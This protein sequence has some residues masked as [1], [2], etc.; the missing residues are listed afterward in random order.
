METTALSVGKSVLNGA[1]DYAKSA[2]AEEVALQFGVQRDRAFVADELEMMQSFMMEAHEERDNNKVVK[3]WVKQV[4]DT[5]YDV[6]DS[7][8]DFA[9]RLERPSWWRFPRTLLER[10]HVAKQMKELRAKVEDVSQRNVRYRLIKD[11]GSKA[12]AATEQSSIIAAS[13]FGVGDARH[14]AKEE[15]HQSVDLVQLINKEADDLKVIAVWGTSGDIGQTTIIREA[16]ENTDVQIKFPC[17]AW[18][19]VMHPFCPKGFVQSL[20]NQFHATEGVEVL[21]KREQTEQDLAQ[22]FNSYVNEKRCLIVL[23]DLSTIEEW[24]QIKKCFQNNKKGSRIV[25]STSQVEVA[26]LC[27]AQESQPSELKQLSPDQTLYAF[28][29]KGSQNGK[30]SGKPA[31]RS[32]MATSSTKNYAVSLCKI[33]ED[34]FKDADGKKVV[35]KSKDSVKPVSSSDTATTNTN[36]QAVALGEITEVE[37][38]DADKKKVVTKSLTRIRTGV[39]AS[40]ESQLI[41][42]EREILEVIDLILNKGNEKGQVISVWGMGGLG[43]TT[44]VNGVYYSPKLSDKFEK[45]VF[46]PIMRPFNPA[47]HLRRLIGG[48]HEGSATKEDLLGNSISNKRKS[49]ASMGVEDLTKEVAKLLETK[50]CLI[51]LDDLSS[52]TEW[53]LRIPKFPQMKT[54]RIIVTTRYE[55]IA[56]HCIGSGKH[57]T[58]H[59]LKVLEPEDA[60]HLFNKKVFGEAKDLVDH[61]N[62][63]LIKEGKQILKKCGGLPLAIVAIGGYLASRPKTGIEWRKLN[64]NIS[65]ELEMNPELG[66]IRTVLAKSYDGLPYELKSCFLYLS[67]FPE[68]HVISRRRLVRRWT[69]E[70]YS[71]ERCGKSAN[72]I[73]ENYF[74]ELKNRSMTLPS[75]RSVRSRKS[76]DSCKVHDLIRDI[77][78]SKS[79][80]ENLVFSLEEGCGS[81][82]HGA[83]RHLAI[84]SNWKGDQSEFESIV[85]LSR[86]RSLTVFGNFR[87]FYISNKMRLLRVLDLEGIDR[88]QYHQL[89]HIWKLLHLKYLSLRGCNGI[90]LLSDSLGNLRQLQL[91]DVRNTCVKALPKAIIKL[92]KLQYIHAGYKSDF[93]QEEKDS[94]MWRCLQ[95]ACL[96]ATCCIPI[97]CDIDG[98]SHKALTRRDACT[99]A[100]CVKFP[101]LMMG[102]GVDEDEGTMV[103][104]GSR[105]LKDLHT[106]REVKV[107]RGIAVLQDI[108]LLTGLRKL[109]VSGI[110]K[111]NGP[112]FRSA[113]SNLNRLES[114]AV[115]SEAGKRGLRGCLDDIS[116]PPEN[117]QSLKL[118]GNLEKLPEWIK[119]LPH[120]VK[121]KLAYTRLSEHDAAMEFLGKLLKLEIL[122]LSGLWS[123]FEGEELY[124]KS[125][126]AGIAFGRL[127]VLS[128]GVRNVKLVKFEEGTMPKVE[129]LL[130]TGRVNNEPVSFS[131]LESLPSI[132]E[133]QL[134]VTFPWDE[135]K[136]TAAR[137]SKTWGRIWEEEEQEQRRKNGELKKKIQEQLAGNTNEPIVTV[138]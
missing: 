17:R 56:K 138:A 110:N 129:R 85:D 134:R 71:S 45:R 66:M 104:R 35:K 30:D 5:A 6:E 86:I 84:S 98:P 116:T 81:S 131:G 59:N 46:V 96:C 18:V 79:I 114:L 68:D 80:E 26:S 34:D 108:K 133:I 33:M 100:C 39:G 67:I 37:S 125:P 106:L 117:L 31:S 128:L 115:R 75:Q 101:A 15:N 126:Q 124:F 14:A 92:R 55:N 132:N 64:E 24:D 111:K 112:A 12:I 27:A 42:R 72:E 1:L 88:L 113:I 107:G 57:G 136:I 22:E 137:D 62:L 119:E 103:P 53:D 78:I 123:L 76:T 50:S 11:S 70:G 13:I 47:E 99:F 8:Q 51:V 25:V 109:G 29:D 38:K 89:D 20:V 94:L 58:I 118:Y 3:T 9:V 90:D 4:R 2:L 41:G 65:A 121:L 48:L 21:L 28:Y 36:N 52:T 61:K 82:T 32:D 69:A 91:L 40:E 54:S 105:K 7:L 97:L 74:T 93:V 127:R 10:R 49:F 73:A 83:I 19:R 77:A 122:V 87:P 95:G 60:L 102:T 135:E 16:Y 44:L 120:L 23:N 130:V 63:E 43:K